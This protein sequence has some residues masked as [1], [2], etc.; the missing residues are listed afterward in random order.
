M[1]NPLA[2]SVGLVAACF[3]SGVL[4]GVLAAGA[5]G[6]SAAAVT[7][8]AAWV[9]IAVAVA[10]AIIGWN[11]VTEARQLRLEQAQP[12]VV[13]FLEPSPADPRMINFVLENFGPTAATA[14]EVSVDPALERRIDQLS[15]EVWLPSRLPILAPGQRWETFWDQSTTRLETDLPK[16]HDITITFDDS[17]NVRHT[18]STEVDWE[19]YLSRGWVTVYGVH[20]AAKSLRKLEKYVASMRES[21]HGGVAVWVRDGDERDERLRR[22]AES[23]RESMRTPD[24]AAAEPEPAES[25][26]PEN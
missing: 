2:R 24:L 8:V 18:T 6:W 15:N 7:A 22:D 16:R 3:A 17:R 10:A 21:I 1:K 12:H 14:V 25:D 26:G 23:Y 5:S 11:Q 20:H 9:A 13:A 19:Q 4:G